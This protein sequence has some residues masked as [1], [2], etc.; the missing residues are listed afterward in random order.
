MNNN[1]SHH[2]SGS[3]FMVHHVRKAQVKEEDYSRC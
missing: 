1:T 3:G 2:E